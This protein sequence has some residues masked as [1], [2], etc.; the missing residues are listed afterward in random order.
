MST[1][2]TSET[3]SAATLNGLGSINQQQKESLEMNLPTLSADFNGQPITMSSREIATLCE[4][5][6]DHI[7]RDIEKMFRDID[8]PNFGAVDFEG[9]YADAKGEMRK[10]YRLPRD[11]T[12]TLVSGYRADLR[13][14]IVKRLE[15]LEA[16]PKLTGPQLM[17][18]ALLEAN[19]TLEA[20]AAQIED[21]REDVEALERIAKA[22]GSITIT[23]A[24]KNLGMR[25]KDLFTWL[26]QNG[27]IYKRAGAANW[28]GYQSKC[29]VSFLE[30]KTTMVLRADGSER[31][32]EQVRITAKGLSKLARLIPGVA[33]EVVA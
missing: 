33:R 4:K 32:T 2:E 5:R 24:A 12:V 9:K 14:R 17:A 13:Y 3:A 23:E 11:L 18:A 31:I 15:E 8:A 10:E 16:A 26:Q 30:H 28:L 1:P 19:A 21:M 20:Q 25:P 29:N 22:D 6:H 7:L 27:W